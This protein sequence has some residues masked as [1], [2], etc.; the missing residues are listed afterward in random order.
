MS[1]TRSRLIALPLAAA[2]V[3]LGLA[4]YQASAAEPVSTHGLPAPCLSDAETLV[5]DL[6]GDAHVDKVNNPW[7]SGTK[8]TVQWGNGDGTYSA[9]VSV[10]SLV[11]TQKGEVTTAAVAD[12]QGD[13]TLDLVVNV[14]EPSS[15]DDPSAPRISEYRPG[16]LD[17]GDLGSADAQQ[18]DIGEAQQLRIADYNKDERPDLAVLANTGDGVRERTVRLT[19]A[20]GTPGAND[21][22]AN[23][24]YG[25]IGTPA[26]LPSMPSDGWKQFYGSCS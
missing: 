16:P 8:T 22:D 6:D 21:A 3:S 23:N 12:F 2:A 18:T 15:G 7:L 11:G 17:R 19:N 24:K 13:G 14:V 20:D 9:P 10:A 4:G 1:R 26:D 5:G 25:E